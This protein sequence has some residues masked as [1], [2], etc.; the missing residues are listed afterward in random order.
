MHYSSARG[1]RTRTASS[2]SP[3]PNSRNVSAN[4]GGNF[5][6][7]AP[8]GQQQQR[9]NNGTFSTPTRNNTTGNS[10]FGGATGFGGGGGGN[11]MAAS[12]APVFG[13]GQTGEHGGFGGSREVNRQPQ[14]HTHTQQ[15]Q[16]QQQQIGTQLAFRVQKISEIV[17]DKGLIMSLAGM[18]EYENKTF[19]EL[20]W[21]DLQ[22]GR[23]GPG[24]LSAPVGAPS[25]GGGAAASSGGTVFGGGGA[26]QPGQGQGGIFGSSG[27]AGL[28]GQGGAAASGAP[29]AQAQT[30][31][32]FGQQQPQPQQQQQQS[33][34]A[35]GQQA[36]PSQ[37]Q[38]PTSGLFGQQ[39]PQGGGAFGQQ[40][41]QG[42][43]AGGGGLF[44]QQ[45]QPNAAATQGQ[46]TGLFGQP[47]QTNAAQGQSA[48]PFGQSQPNPATQ[49]QA[50]GLFG[51]PAAQAQTGG[52]FGQQQPAQAQT[53][54]L[55]GQTQQ[56]Q[57]QQPAQA[58]P[59]GL[60][61]QT[62]QQQ[63]PAAQAQTGGAFGQTQQQQPAAQ[64][65]TGG[66]F[67]QTQ[68]QQQ[69]QQQQ[70]AQAQPAGLFGQTQQQQ[71]PAAQAQTGGAFGQT[72]QQQQQ[73]AAQA[74]TGGLF[75]Q[76]QQQ[77]QQ[78]QP[79]A[80]A[81]TA[82][83]FGQ[84]SAQPTQGASVGGG[85]LF[86]GGASTASPAPATG[87]A[88]G[89]TPGASSALQQNPQQQQQNVAQTP[90]QPTELKRHSC[91]YLLHHSPS[92]GRG[93]PPMSPPEPS[94]PPRPPKP[95]PLFQDCELIGAGHPGATRPSAY[96]ERTREKS[97][98]HNFPNFGTPGTSFDTRGPHGVSFMKG[99]QADNRLSSRSAGG[100]PP[101]KAAAANLPF[102]SSYQTPNLGQETGAPYSTLGGQE[103][104]PP[105][106][107][108]LQSLGLDL[109]QSCHA[110]AAREREREREKDKR[111]MEKEKVVQR[112]GGAS[113][114]SNAE[115]STKE[116]SSMYPSLQSSF[117]STI[118][119]GPPGVS[120]SSPSAPASS[121]SSPV[122]G[123]LD[124]PPW[125]PKLTKEGVKTSPGIATLQAF[126]KQ[127]IRRVADFQISKDGYG[128][129]LWPGM[130]DLEGVDLDACVQFQNGCVSVYED[131]VEGK[132]K[133]PRGT[134]LN[135]RARITVLCAPPP[136]FVK[137]AKG[138]E[139]V[140]F[141]IWE[142]KL[143]EVSAKQNAQFDSLRVKTV[144][145]ELEWRWEFY[146]EHFTKYGLELDRDFAEEDAGNAPSLPYQAGRIVASSPVPESRRRESVDPMTHDD[147][148]AFR[149]PAPHI[150]T[151]RYPRFDEH[152]DPSYNDLEGRQTEPP[153]P[154]HP[155][156]SPM[157]H[158]VDFFDQQE[159]D[160]LAAPSPFFSS[161]VP[162]GGQP[163][164]EFGGARL[165]PYGPSGYP[166][167][168]PAAG[169]G[170]EQL[171]GSD[172]LP[173][174]SFAGADGLLYRD[175]ANP[176]S[177]PE[178][179]R[180]L[181]PQGLGG[182][183]CFT[184]ISLT[185]PSV[186]VPPGKRKRD[187]DEQERVQHA[188]EL[189][190]TLKDSR[191][192]SM[193]KRAVEMTMFPNEKSTR[194][195]HKFASGPSGFSL[196]FAL[197]IVH[198][199]T[200]KLSIP[201]TTGEGVVKSEKTNAPFAVGISLV[202]RMGKAVAV[203]GAQWLRSVVTAQIEQS[204]EVE[205]R[206]N[207]LPRLHLKWSE[208]AVTRVIDAQIHIACEAASVAEGGG[209]PTG[210]SISLHHVYSRDTLFLFRALW[211]E[212]RLSRV[213]RAWLA[214]ELKSEVQGGDESMGMGGEGGEDV[215][216]GEGKAKG[217]GQIEKDRADA[218]ESVADW[219]QEVT[220]R[221]RQASRSTGRTGQSLTR[222]RAAER[223]KVLDGAFRAALCAV[224]EDRP[225]GVGASLLL[226]EG[227]AG[228]SRRVPPRPDHAMTG[229][230]E[231]DV[232][233]RSALASLSICG[234][235]T[236]H[237]ASKIY[238]G[239]ATMLDP[240][241]EQ[242]Q[243]ETQDWKGRYTEKA[244]MD[245]T[246]AASGKMA[247]P[248]GDLL[249]AVS[250]DAD[251]PLHQ[252]RD[253]REALLVLLRMPCEEAHKH[254]GGDWRLQQAL[255]S[256]LKKASEGFCRKVPQ[257]GPVLIA[258]PPRPPYDLP[259]R[260]PAESQ[261]DP[262]DPD[263]TNEPT[264]SSSSSS[265]SDMRFRAL[266]LSEQQWKGVK[267]RGGDTGGLRR[268]EQVE[269][270]H[271]GEKLDLQFELL[272][273]LAF[274]HLDLSVLDVRGYSRDG[275]DICLSWILVVNLAH[276]LCLS[277]VPT[278]GSDG[279]TAMSQEILLEK[280][281]KIGEVLGRCSRL[282]IDLLGELGEWEAA[283]GVHLLTELW[284][285]ASGSLREQPGQLGPDDPTG[286]G[287][288]FLLSSPEG[289]AVESR[290]RVA[291]AC[292]NLMMRGK[293]TDSRRSE[294]SR[295][296]AAKLVEFLQLPDED[297]LFGSCVPV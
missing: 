116:G 177:A 4:T 256:L 65:Q 25:F 208:E 269:D 129:I 213:L 276:A 215:E 193:K 220:W 204:V 199:F 63:Q 6:F 109:S 281:K 160:N 191:W 22:A 141:Q 49:G 293:A 28:F 294:E 106:T 233:P 205:G 219:L 59:A 155:E 131:Q 136:S 224:G 85:N 16:Q 102:G 53:G 169:G 181:K 107:Q 190:A 118:P 36:Q 250:G 184:P 90:S 235:G 197:H 32:L 253:W 23:R 57:Q 139:E 156:G 113:S 14:T 55:F 11:R 37:A 77:Q 218:V 27:G 264:I 10:I 7:G 70:P 40:S 21:E 260:D 272:R 24:A 83:T 73:P 56:Q 3:G 225:T 183:D 87:Q 127:Q 196:S 132:D 46:A 89:E 159:T 228:A 108:G 262:G 280:L 8:Q 263:A 140:L 282:M 297:L 211:G 17:N 249:M 275:L 216:D 287:S 231:V 242:M 115:S 95:A 68:Q 79:A 195:G 254:S 265:N 97:S 39:Q 43:A 29:Q 223:E 203:G 80:Q 255:R 138:R 52:A 247:I 284:E 292:G 238:D 273:F 110:A 134:K 13:R 214:S 19:E 38:P 15:Q 296:E 171:G 240:R 124:L 261:R 245:F 237:V 135:K 178:V 163:G 212:G 72:Q 18:R 128:S 143:R 75:G 98:F 248:V 105:P 164:A 101:S 278:G 176:L 174:G 117:S 112:Q 148:S 149:R 26:G 295:R 166:E 209:V 201:Y 236:S 50:T 60:F 234:F 64:A 173:H 192:P 125:A 119:L 194:C 206:E 99:A 162:R 153:S 12:A 51:Q 230:S 154:T 145:G 69:Q 88:S 286:P 288:A 200:P 259:S 217:D 268:E 198:R 92:D 1:A 142:E 81:Q 103:N 93:S 157:R 279:F 168:I 114:S 82:A 207:D 121:A 71:Q 104:V 47:Q 151:S 144:A 258:P 78:Q 86:G 202:K 96:S 189:I 246:A 285:K 229:V 221:R 165:E 232:F 274:P 210:G 122:P 172:L 266:D 290:R 62:Q 227:D 54:G 5:G 111:Q 66:L 146:V 150:V 158:D 35:F 42:Q 243:P 9:G 147:T 44:G 84:G 186:A 20:R 58:Q 33:F 67:G 126:S 41:Q 241:S 188:I 185:H 277:A 76:T 289:R 271:S 123:S 45:T 179:E 2:R 239:P 48:A 175:E 291:E 133:P 251:A 152:E 31:G 120:E 167:T 270:D 187:K 94:P 226:E 222:R 244:L 267:E 34:G 100:P 283:V 30:G 161:T 182:T 252:C 61:G 91:W 170:G 74:Q 257:R 137:R 180:P 130:T